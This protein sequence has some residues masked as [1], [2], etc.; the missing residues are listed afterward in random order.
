MAPWLRLRLDTH[1][2]KQDGNP[3][4]FSYNIWIYEK[5]VLFILQRRR[6]VFMVTVVSALPL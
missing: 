6:S 2:K 1:L 5:P 3:F 4:F